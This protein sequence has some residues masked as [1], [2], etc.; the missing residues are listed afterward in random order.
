MV[1]SSNLEGSQ[2]HID[3]RA[4]ELKQPPGIE[5]RESFDSDLA[6]LLSN[7]DKRE[8]PKTSSSEE[9]KYSPEQYF[10]SE[11][12]GKWFRVYPKRK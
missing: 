7:I 12:T 9:Q 1:V 3:E 4:E 8:G 5:E 6:Q 11:S 2:R 10:S